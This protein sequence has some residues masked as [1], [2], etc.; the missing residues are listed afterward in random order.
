MWGFPVRPLNFAR[1]I[2]SLCVIKRGVPALP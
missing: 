2:G 1:E